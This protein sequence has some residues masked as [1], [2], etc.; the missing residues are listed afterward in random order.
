[1]TTLNERRREMA[2]LRANGAR[3]WQIAALLLFEAGLITVAGIIMGVLIALASLVMAAP[4]VLD[5]FG[6]A[7]GPSMPEPWQLGVLAL[8][9]LAGLLV[10][11]V[12]ATMAYRRTLTDGMQV[13]T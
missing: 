1:M 2:I 11:L 8:I 12:P 10:A 13:R 5:T 9:A 7:V 4:W 3:P 6:L